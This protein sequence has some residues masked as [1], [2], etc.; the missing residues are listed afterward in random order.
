[1]KIAKLCLVLPALIALLAVSVLADSISTYSF[2]A[3]IA[4]YYSYVASP[5]GGYVV[6]EITGPQSLSG[7]FSFDL[8]TNRLSTWSFDLAPLEGVAEQG[9]LAGMV[10]GVYTNATVQPVDVNGSYQ[11]TDQNTI[12]NVQSNPYFFD[13]T[14]YPGDDTAVALNPSYETEVTFELA[15]LPTG[16]GP[17]ALV[18]TGNGDGGLYQFGNNGGTYAYSTYFTSGS[19]ALVTPEPSTWT[20][21]GGGVMLLAGFA[22]WS[23]TRRRSRA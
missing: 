4:S 23:D 18:S 15:S 3:T 6:E 2:N 5:Y 21:M 7:N 22:L 13:I 9:P 20:L 1:M 8:T 16:A 17:V 12:Q 19:V 10:G 14:N 11:V